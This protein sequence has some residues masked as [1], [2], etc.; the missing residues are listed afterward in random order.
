[1]REIKFRAWDP[2]AKK[3]Y[4]PEALE[5]PEIEESANKTIYSYLSY[6]VL[7]IYDFRGKEPLEFVP[8]QFTGWYDRNKNEIYEGDIVQWEESLHQIIWSDEIS[9]FV[10]LSWDG[11]V[12]MG[13]EFLTDT[14]E[15]VGNIYEDPGL[16]QYR[17]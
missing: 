16:F 3:M 6:G 17:S 1:M 11:M 13:G 8:L 2:E 12:S 5:Q 10:I 9:A 15:V 4:S 7:C 14:I